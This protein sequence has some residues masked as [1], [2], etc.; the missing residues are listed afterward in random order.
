MTLQQVEKHIQLERENPSSVSLSKIA[1]YLEIIHLLVR[2]IVER[3]PL[4]DGKFRWWN[5]SLIVDIVK[6]FREIIKKLTA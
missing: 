6:L 4:K 1:L 5:V 2:F 3:E